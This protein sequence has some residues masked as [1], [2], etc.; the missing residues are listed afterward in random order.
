MSTQR[1]G[2]LNGVNLL[3][4]KDIQQSVY[5][6]RLRL[7]LDKKRT[8]VSKTTARGTSHRLAHTYFKSSSACRRMSA[9]ASSVD[10]MRFR[11]TATSISLRQR[12]PGC[13]N[14]DSEKIDGAQK[15]ALTK[16]RNRGGQRGQGGEDKRGI[17]R[18]SN[19][20]FSL[21]GFSGGVGPASRAANQTACRPA[22]GKRI[23]VKLFGS[24]DGYWI[25]Q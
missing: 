9:L 18:E 5:K 7:G 23:F 2:Q 19:F 1:T 10:W 3:A 24:G 17:N 8:I 16:W 13:R 22:R 14:Q 25:L 20:R 15:N 4:L 6:T 11:S 21:S 12:P